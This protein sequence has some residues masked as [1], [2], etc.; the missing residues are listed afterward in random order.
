MNITAT[1]T[2][3]FCNRNNVCLLLPLAGQQHKKA[4]HLLGLASLVAETQLPLKV[5]VAPDHGRT[6]LKFLCGSCLFFRCC[7]S[8]HLICKYDESESFIHRRRHR[9]WS[10]SSK[11]TILSAP[12]QYR[13]NFPV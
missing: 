3:S 4:K 13:I 1:V 10:K 12:R 2:Y 5:D 6:A 8:R 11:T 7:S 9:R